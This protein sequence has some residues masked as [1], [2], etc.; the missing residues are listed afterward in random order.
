[1]FFYLFYNSKI[2]NA[3]NDQQKNISTLIYGSIIYIILHAIL[4]FKNNNEFL[5]NFQKYFWILFTLDCISVLF[6]HI[7]KNNTMFS[8]NINFSKPSSSKNKTI[9]EIKNLKNDISNL[10][11]KKI[12]KNI[13]I[14][15]EPIEKKVRFE[16]K[17]DSDSEVASV[18][19]LGN[20]SS[21]D[22][23]LDEFEK[24]LQDKSN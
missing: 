15:I 8:E 1:M 16:D 11:N 12:K 5:K 7:S 21:S 23:D 2:I 10:K 17:V 3:N 18:S 6:T 22:Y 9:S 24:M 14:N 19:D 20:A 4:F 13:N